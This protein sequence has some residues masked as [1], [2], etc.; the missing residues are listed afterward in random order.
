VRQIGGCGVVSSFLVSPVSSTAPHPGEAK[1]GLGPDEH[2]TR[3]QACSVAISTFFSPHRSHVLAEEQLA[4]HTS[5]V[6]FI[7]LFLHFYVARAFSSYAELHVH[8][9]YERPHIHAGAHHQSLNFL[10]RDA[11]PGWSNPC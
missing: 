1:R 10:N 5:E 3:K 4:A 9:W 6:L 7:C 11:F 8:T 2:P